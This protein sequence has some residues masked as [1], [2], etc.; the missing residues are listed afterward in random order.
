MI[1]PLELERRARQASR[2]EQRAFDLSLSR[3]I[4]NL[5]REYQVVYHPGE[6]VPSD[7]SM[8]KDVF[9]ASLQLLL[10]IG[11][12][13]VELGSAARVSEEEVRGALS[14]A[15]SEVRL[16]VGADSRVLSVRKPAS[17]GKPFVFGGY[18]GTPTPEEIFKPSALSYALEPLVDALD[19]GS[20]TSVAGLSLA[21]S[22]PSEVE[23][24][25]LEIRLLREAIEEAGRPGLHLLA[26]ESSTSAVANAAAMASGLLRRSDA[27]LIPILNEM[28]VGYD[29]L[30]KAHTGRLYSVHNA[31]LV[32]PIVGGF[33]RG[34][35]GTAICA[36]A[37]AL[38]SMVAYGASYVLVHPYHIH[39][40]ATSARECLWVE[41]VLGL[42]GERL[43]VPLVGDVWPA[44]GGGCAEMLY[45][46]AANSIV[47]A[48]C[49]LNLLGPA[50]ANGE[51]PH[52]SG[53]EAMFMAEV[54][55][56]AAALKPS[57]AAEL[58]GELL[59]FYESSLRNP[60]PGV[61]FG[62]L[63][64]LERREPA[65]WWASVY[66]RVREHV[67]DLGLELE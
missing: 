53:L 50:P 61:P 66:R 28:K 48:S 52:G 4:A 15:K 51:K 55:A 5:E 35:A 18:A 24:T 59:R 19:H 2:L 67:A 17:G 34:A 14:S 49:G 3:A 56:A 31:A 57:H 27:Q 20:L 47:A 38:T 9:E 62:E 64:D 33:A 63:Y 40:K 22:A 41:A 10:E 11:I 54:G 23:A 6:I 29:Q 7:P 21:R 8:V 30:L 12:Y 13:I 44:N 37:E 16:G 65:P 42:A 36:V 58:A 43:G 1:P 39:L 46:I 26:C 60:N 32:D 25:L 45:E